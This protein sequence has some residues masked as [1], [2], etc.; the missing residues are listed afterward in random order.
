MPNIPA[1]E[2]LTNQNVRQQLADGGF[3]RSNL[4]QVSI[5]DGW[6]KNED[7]NETPFINYL[8]RVGLKENYAVDWNATFK[9]KLA[10]SCS[11]ATLPTSSFAT[12]EVKTNYIGVPQEYAHTRI[13]PDIDF[14]FYVDRDY[15]NIMFFEAWM[16]FVSGGSQMGQYDEPARSYYRRF[17][18]PKHYKNE[19]GV[20]ITKFERNY[21]TDGATSITYQLISA[22]PKNVSIV[23]L[24][25]GEAE[26]MKVTVTMNYDRYKV[27]RTN[28]GLVSILPIDLDDIVTLPVV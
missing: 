28:V 14:S 9:R 19:N 18:Y 8:N 22:F 12:G 24:S 10:F 17:N 11:D 5:Q 2:T 16:D 3:A 7:G 4:F 6:G 27:Y 23:P 13:M 1:I 15:K 25:Y 21:M 26:V 20:Y